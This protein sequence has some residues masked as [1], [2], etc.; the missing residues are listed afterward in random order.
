MSRA[1]GWPRALGVPAAFAGVMLVGALLG[2]F[3]VP[4]LLVE[5]GILASV[6]AF[7]L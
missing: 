7:G 4:V 6:V 1:E 5:P 3:G 2:M